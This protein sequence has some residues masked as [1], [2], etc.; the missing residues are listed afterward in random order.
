MNQSIQVETAQRNKRLLALF[1]DLLC[2]AASTVCLFF[3]LLFVVIGPMFNYKGN[4]ESVFNTREK[5]HLNLGVAEE[6]TKYIEGFQLFFEDEVNSDKI[7]EYTKRYYPAFDPEETRSPLE[8]VRYAYNVLILD[9]PV[10][11]THETY[12]TSYYQYQFKEHSTSEFDLYQYGVL[13]N[14]KPS[15]KAKANLR[16][17]FSWKME[18]V[19][20]MLPYVIPTYKEALRFKSNVELFSRVIAMALS[21]IVFAIALPIILKNGVTL[22]GKLF[23]VAI[24]RN[25]TALRIKWYRNVYRALALFTLPI[26]GIGLYDRYGTVIFM[27]FPVFVSILMMLFK[28]SGRDL[29]DVLSG[30]IAVDSNNSFFFSSAGEARLFEK[31]DNYKQVSDPDFLKALESVDSFNVDNEKDNNTKITKN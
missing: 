8:K 10:S 15:D 17:F 1:F 27:I 26:F 18:T 4:C 30:T 6:Y 22:G 5:Y 31:K 20:D 24:V 9:L 19:N 28:E 21:V 29:Q 3:L 2:I 25:K 12:K 13:I 11:P 16:D 7:I 23:K 14:P